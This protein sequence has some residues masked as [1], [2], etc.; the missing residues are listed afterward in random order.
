MI[1]VNKAQVSALMDGELDD[2][3]VKDLLEDVSIRQTWHRYHL[4]SDVLQNHIPLHTDPQLTLR[5]SELIKNEP[6]IVAPIRRNTPAYLKPLTG[7][8]VAASVT[9]MAILGVQQFRAG[10][11]G[12]GVST[13]AQ[14]TNALP[15]SQVGVPIEPVVAE[16]LRPVQ[17]LVQG[18]VLQANVNT[19]KM[20]RYILNHNEYQSNSGVHGVTPHVRLV[21]TDG[22]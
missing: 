11:D 13:I 7:L 6:A 10:P 9:A 3:A 12:G 8:A 21:A 14:T 5:I 2:N 18:P 17:P 16:N 22:K 20:S 4:I 1:D 15:A 19:V